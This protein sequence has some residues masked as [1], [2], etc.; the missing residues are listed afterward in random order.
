MFNYRRPKNHRYNSPEYMPKIIE[1][2]YNIGGNFS[3]ERNN[4]EMNYN[5]KI[6]KLKTSTKE[7]NNQLKIYREDLDDFYEENKIISSKLRLDYKNLKNELNNNINIVKE[8]IDKNMNEQNKFNQKINKDFL[9]LKQ[10]SSNIQGLINDVTDRL[11][12]LNKKLLEKK[13]NKNKENEIIKNKDLCEG[14][15]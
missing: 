2:M 1:K 5:I 8:K 3:Y 7:L 4:S 12:N 10:Y 11:N 6:N 9:E 14:K 13:S 15:I